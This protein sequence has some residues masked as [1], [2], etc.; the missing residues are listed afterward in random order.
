LGEHIPH[1][2]GKEKKREKTFDEW[3]QQLFHFAINAEPKDTEYYKQLKADLKSAWD[4]GFQAGC[5]YTKGT[6]I[7][8]ALSV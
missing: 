2:K 3:Y 6:I 7:K 8:K 4:A 5:Q 1:G